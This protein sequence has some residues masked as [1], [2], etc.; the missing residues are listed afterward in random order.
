MRRARGT[1]AYRVAARNIH[2]GRARARLSRRGTAAAAP[3]ALGRP[4]AEL[5]RAMGLLAFESERLARVF[6]GTANGLPVSRGPRPRAK[7]HGAQL[8]GCDAVVFDEFWMHK[9]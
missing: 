9:E 1:E 3:R 6:A 2:R 4:V 5:A 8:T 7:A